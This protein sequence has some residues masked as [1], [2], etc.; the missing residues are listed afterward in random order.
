MAEN[1]IG[2]FSDHATAAQ[3]VSQLVDAGVPKDEISLMTRRSEGDEV[4]PQSSGVF[5]KNGD[6]SSEGGSAILSGVIGSF[7]GTAIGVATFTI[8]GVGLI[9]G[10][11]PLATAVCGGAL[12]AAFGGEMGKDG[13]APYNN[14]NPLHPYILSLKEGEV[15]CGVEVDR[16]QEGP[17]R[18][19]M[20]N[21]ASSIVS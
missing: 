7:V 14:S 13:D 9:V 16:D 3:C 5:Q 8:P 20:A 1:I 11:G 19:I 12:G 18:L 15:L 21:N 6:T 2:I 4:E 17:V 10:A